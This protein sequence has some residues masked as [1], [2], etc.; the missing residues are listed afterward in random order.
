[1][2]ITFSCLQLLIDIVWTNIYCLKICFNFSFLANCSVQP[3][4]LS[5]SDSSCSLSWTAYWR[6]V[7]NYFS[8]KENNVCMRSIDNSWDQGVIGRWNSSCSPKT[9]FYSTWRVIQFARILALLCGCI[10]VTEQDK[11]PYYKYTFP[12]KA[13]APQPHNACIIIR[14]CEHASDSN[15]FSVIYASYSKLHIVHNFV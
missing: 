4:S 1:M 6:V 9:P 2:D 8:G 15:F 12:T 7:A 3:M 14:S 13:L 11:I 5:D 10:D